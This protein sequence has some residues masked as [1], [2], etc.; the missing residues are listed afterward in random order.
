MFK[1]KAHGGTHCAK[2]LLGSHVLSPDEAGFDVQTRT[3]EYFCLRCGRRV[4]SVS[5]E[6]FED[7]DYE[8]LFHILVSGKDTDESTG[9]AELLSQA[10]SPWQEIFGEP[11]AATVQR[12]RRG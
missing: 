5:A 6:E 7:V 8:V 2:A 12:H 3:L 11:V 9:K 1:K 4:H 10:E